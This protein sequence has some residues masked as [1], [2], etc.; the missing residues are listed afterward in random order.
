[1]SMRR[2]A[3]PVGAAGEAMNAEHPRH[4]YAPTA[5]S[6]GAAWRGSVHVL[7]FASFRP[8]AGGT[9]AP[10]R[11]KTRTTPQR[12]VIC[13]SDSLTAATTQASGGGH[14]SGSNAAANLRLRDIPVECEKWSGHW[15]P[16]RIGTVVRS[17]EQTLRRNSAGQDR[18][19]LHTPS[20]A[21]NDAHMATVDPD[22]HGAD[23]DVQS[24]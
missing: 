7:P 21:S 24:P 4:T 10:Y 6:N 1:M 15:G 23:A 19:I 18:S 17:L 16:G 13:V 11:S 22:P 5:R 12:H 20:Y 2:K 9:S 8:H 14:A 3:R